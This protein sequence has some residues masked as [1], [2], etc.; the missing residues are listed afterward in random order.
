M[1][2]GYNLILSLILASTVSLS[3]CCTKHHYVAIK[4]RTIPVDSRWDERT[5]G[6]PET[7]VDGYKIEIDNIMS[8]VIGRSRVDMVVKRPENP[9]SNLIADVLRNSTIPYIGRSADLALINIGG[10]R[11]NLNKGDITYGN[12]YEILP[13][14]NSLCI[15]YLKGSDV[16]E[17][18]TNIV[19][20]GG[21]GVSNVKLVADKD[22][23]IVTALIGGQPI[24]EEQTY[25]VATVDYLAEGNDKMTALLKAEKKVCQSQ[26]TIRNLFLN[27]V[28][29]LNRDGKEVSSAVEGRIEL[30]Q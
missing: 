22:K 17:L 19:R 29:D 4:S 27:Y 23:N 14:E 6:V 12:I 30:N 20:V 3:S 1:I 10:L 5:D 2:K 26:A 9:L 25:V 7:I 13:F 15:L 16:K 28:D 18:M 24:E 8:P 11:A 21:E